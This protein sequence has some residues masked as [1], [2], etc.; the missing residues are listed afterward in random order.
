MA[1]NWTAAQAIK[2]IRAGKNKE[3]IMDIG[4]RF[5]L[6]AV[7]AASNPVEIVEALPDF[8]S[9][10]KIEAILKGNVDTSSEAEDDEDS[11]SEEDEEVESKPKKKASESKSK[12]KPAKEEDEDEVDDEGEEEEEEPKSKKK[13]KL[14][15]TTIINILSRKTIHTIIVIYFIEILF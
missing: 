11:E 8:I 13:P 5:P 4:R 15:F 6:F 14:T 10:R 9:A 2:V 1:K 12:K 7:I 3:D